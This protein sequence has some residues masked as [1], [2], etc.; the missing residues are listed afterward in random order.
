MTGTKTLAAANPGGGAR[1]EAGARRR[2]APAGAALTACALLLAVFALGAAPAIAFDGIVTPKAFTFG[3]P[4]N[5]FVLENGEKLGPITVVYETYGTLDPDGRN[6]I[7]VMHGQNGHAHAA[8]RHTPDGPLGWWDG[9]IGPGK[10]FDT[11]R[12]FVVSPQ[13]LAGGYL[14]HR[15]GTGTTGPQSVNPK[16]GKPYGMSFAT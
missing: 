16:T 5:E 13:A 1:R 14:D 7:L 12:Y 4:P 6:A 3:Q 15:P 8:G 9:A 11:D 10:P 2:R